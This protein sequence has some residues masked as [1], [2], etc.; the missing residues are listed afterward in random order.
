MLGRL[1]GQQIRYS[2]SQALNLSLPHTIQHQCM[3][4]FLFKWQTKSITYLSIQ[5][6]ANLTNLYSLNHVPLLQ[7]LQQDLTSWRTMLLS[8]FGRAAAIKMNLLPQVLYML[9]AIPMH[10]PGAFFASLRSAAP[11]QH[12]HLLRYTTLHY[13]SFTHSFM[14]ATA[15]QLGKQ[16]LSRNTSAPEAKLGLSPHQRQSQLVSADTKKNLQAMVSAATI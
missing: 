14:L 6:P 3:R 13:N 2:K 4:D 12:S 10:L 9:Q 1:I 11:L 16:P 15:I 7:S 5:L 8:W